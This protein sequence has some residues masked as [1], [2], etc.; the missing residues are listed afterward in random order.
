MVGRLVPVAPH[1]I[2]AARVGW[3]VRVM[4]GA[5]SVVLPGRRLGRFGGGDPTV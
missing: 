2:A 1:G 3:L 5:V 4:I